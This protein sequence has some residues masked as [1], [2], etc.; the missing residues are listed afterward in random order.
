MSI[1]ELTEL[2]MQLQDLLD[3]NYIYPSV[4]PCGALV[5]VAKKKDETL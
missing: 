5:L 1:P 3:K 4:S 2:N